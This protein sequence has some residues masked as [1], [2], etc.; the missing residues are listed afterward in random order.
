M[1]FNALIKN[2]KQTHTVLKTA[3]SKAINISLTIRNWL[4]GYYIVEFEQNGEDRAKYGKKVLQNLEKHFKESDIKGLTERRFR[5]YR[6]FYITYPEIRQALTAEFIHNN[7]PFYKLPIRQAL[8]AEI[9]QDDIQEERI[10][11]SMPKQFNNNR[12]E[13]QISSKKLLSY[14]SFTHFVELVKIEDNLKRTFY[15]LECIKG[16]WSARELARQI[17]SL[18][19]ERSGLSKDKQKLSA[20]VNEKAVKLIPQDI[21]NS[22]FAFEFLGL[23]QRALITESELEQALLDNLQSFLIEMGYGFCF[24]ARQKRILI[25]DEYYF[26]DLVFYHRILK[27]HVLVDLKID[28]FKHKYASQLNTYL[29]YY[30]AEIQTKDDNSPVGILLCSHKNDTLVQYATVGLAENIFVEKYLI[31]LPSKKKLKEY[32]N[33]ELNK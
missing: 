14:L 17:H 4:I 32:I 27:C 7:I 19:F 31:E 5:E 22:P 15:E 33:S 28:K 16:N 30:K 29:N 24:E 6:K 25:G 13:P 3:V 21:I 18:Y 12:K 10:V 1:N 20:I 26:I 8:T 2:I 23:N 11:Q 9:K